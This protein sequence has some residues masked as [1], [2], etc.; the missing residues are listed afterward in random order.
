MK[1][2]MERYIELERAYRAAQ[3]GEFHSKPLDSY[4]QDAKEAVDRALAA[5]VQFEREHPELAEE[6]WEHCQQQ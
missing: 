5:L 4:Y 1:E 3:L 6:I 2:G